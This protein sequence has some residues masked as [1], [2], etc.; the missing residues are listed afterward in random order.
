MYVKV[1]SQILE[2]SIAVDYQQRHIF[3]DLLKL[4]DR[5]GII[6]MTPEAIGRRLNVPEELVTQNI[7]KLEQPDP[8]SRSDEAEGRRLLRI[9]EHREWGWK[10]V[11]YVFY[12]D[13]I[14]SEALRAANRERKREQRARERAAKSP[15]VSQSVRDNHDGHKKSLPQ[16]HT[17]SH[18]KLQKEEEQRGMVNG[19]VHEIIQPVQNAAEDLSLSSES[20]PK[21]KRKLEARPKSWEEFLAFCEKKEIGRSDAEYLYNHWQANGW[22][23]GKKKIESWHHAV[24]SWKSGGFLPSQKTK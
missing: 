1:F 10:V 23:T 4:A 18:S 17:Q 8:L 11:N 24:Q 3:E 22:W 20:L 16:S 6:D 5:E 13:L 15:I 21:P 7:H 14:D 9:A 19:V 12:R 2:S